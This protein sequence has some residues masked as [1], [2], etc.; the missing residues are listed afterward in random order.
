MDLIEIVFEDV[1]WI[2]VA[3]DRFQMQAFPNTVMNLQAPKEA[4]NL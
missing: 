2:H 1:D 4:G 3:W